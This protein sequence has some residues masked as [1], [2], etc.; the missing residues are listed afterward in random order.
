MDMNSLLMATA[1]LLVGLAALVLG[2]FLGF[3]AWWQWRAPR[4]VTL[5]AAPRQAGSQPPPAPSPPAAPAPPPAPALSARE[6]AVLAL[7]ARPDLTHEQIADALFI[8]PSTLK[9]H[10]RHLG[11]KFGVIGRAAI[12]AAAR[13]RGLLPPADAP[14]PPETGTGEGIDRRPPRAD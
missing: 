4:F 1:L 11:E 12:V 3:S 14:A 7:L 10:I 6:A 5:D 9:S 2:V 8:R 13:Q